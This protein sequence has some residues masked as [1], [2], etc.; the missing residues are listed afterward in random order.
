MTAN[1]YVRHDVLATLTDDELRDIIAQGGP[2]ALIDAARALL[3]DRV[4]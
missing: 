3:K 4:A 1:D 2:A